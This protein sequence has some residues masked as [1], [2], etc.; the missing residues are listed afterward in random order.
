MLS[1]GFYQDLQE[2]NQVGRGSL[3]T[4]RQ[5]TRDEWVDSARVEIDVATLPFPTVSCSF[6]LPDCNWPALCLSW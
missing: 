6:S 4:Q 2:L 3:Y 5:T 1:I